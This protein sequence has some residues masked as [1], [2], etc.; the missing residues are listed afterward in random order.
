MQAVAHESFILYQLESTLAITQDILSLR[1]RPCNMDHY[2]P[3]QAGQYVKV[4]LKN[5]NHITTLPLSVANIST[6]MLE[7]HLRYN[8]TQT[9]VQLLLEQLAATPILQISGPFGNMTTANIIFDDSPLLLLAG[10]TGIAPFKALLEQLATSPTALNK[11]IDLL[12]GISKPED[13]YLA[14]FF[15]KIKKKLTNLHVEVVLSHPQTIPSSFPTGFLDEHL[16]KK[17]TISRYRQAYLSG[18]YA[19]V[20]KCH[21]HLLNQGLSEALILSDMISSTL[22]KHTVPLP[23][24]LLPLS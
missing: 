15:E 20:Q 13:F 17:S 23:V 4:F 5:T 8:K 10:G 18:P 16:A 24:S 2:I 19:M 22:S 6:A 12:W 1:C 9:A 14:D 21:T 11:P 7:F 3:F